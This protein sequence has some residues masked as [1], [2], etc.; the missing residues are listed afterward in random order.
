MHDALGCGRCYRTF[1]VV[2]DFNPEALATG[3]DLH[4]PAQQVVKVLDRIVAN[5]LRYVKTDRVNRGCTRPE[6]T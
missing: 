1:N 2:D 3:I 6:F 5:I 4:I